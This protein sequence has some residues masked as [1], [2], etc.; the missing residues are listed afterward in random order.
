MSIMCDREGIFQGRILE[1]G[2][3]EF[4]SGAVAISIRAALD[5]IW[6]GE[7]WI[8]IKDW[9]M[10]AM[11]SLFIIKKDNGGVNNQQVESIV[12]ATAWDG[13]INSVVHGTWQPIPC[14]FAIKSETYKERTSFKIAFV[15]EHDREPTGNIS[16]VDADKAKQLDAKYGS[17][18]RAVSGN[19]KRNSSPAPEGKKMPAPSQPSASAQGAWKPPGA[20]AKAPAVAVNADGIPF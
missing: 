10:E 7:E 12:K 1:Y 2:L 11:G 18:L 15:N 4:E 6:N 5:T 9:A 8:D 14:Q 19:V 13:G 20:E 17:S 3:K 16:N